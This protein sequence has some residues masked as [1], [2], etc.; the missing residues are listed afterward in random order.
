MDVHC[1]KAARYFIRNH[2]A[3]KWVK[4]WQ[5]RDKNGTQPGKRTN[6]TN[7]KDPPCYLAG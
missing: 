6:I 4:I 1:S 5:L 7:W 2:Q 3:K